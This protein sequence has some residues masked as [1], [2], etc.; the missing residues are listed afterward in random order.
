MFDTSVLN[1]PAIER[2]Y[3]F[4]NTSSYLFRQLRRE[5]SVKD[6]ADQASTGELF[7]II[8]S[9]DQSSERKPR[10]LAIAYAATVAL[11]HHD[12]TEVRQRV[13]HLQL[14]N[15]EWVIAILDLWLE[16]LIVTDI[17][18]IQIR[19]RVASPGEHLP[20]SSS[21]EHFDLEGGSR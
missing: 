1:L 16:T 21:T 5:E 7:N 19:P 11:T 8:L 18:T 20:S 17:H 2:A 6:L 14:Q 3:L 12:P 4:A 15:L 13:K 9:V 10:R